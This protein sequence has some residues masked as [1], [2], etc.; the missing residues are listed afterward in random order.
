MC[1]TDPEVVSDL[2]SLVKILRDIVYKKY[3]VH[4]K[5]YDLSVLEKWK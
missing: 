5:R 3:S 4:M 2:E 1:M